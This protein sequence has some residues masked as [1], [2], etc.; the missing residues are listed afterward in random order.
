MADTIADH[1]V[2]SL[3][4]FR[5]LVEPT[6]ALSFPEPWIQRKIRDEQ[7]KFKVW[8][9]NI[10]AHKTGTGSLDYRLR[11]ASP[12]K[13]QVIELLEDLCDLLSQAIAIAS[14]EKIPWDQLDGE[15][16]V[17]DADTD[18]PSTELGQI[19]TEGVADV[20]DCLLRLSMT[21]RNPAPHDRFIMSQSA[22]TTYFEPFD[23]QHVQSK[24]PL[25]EPWLAERLGKATSRRRQYFRYR[26]SHHA[27]LSQGLDDTDPAPKECNETI[28]SSIPSHLK[29]KGKQPTILEDDRSDAGAS[30]TSYA[31]SIAEEGALRVPPLPEE[32]HE[33]PFQCPFCYVMVL[34]TDRAAW[35]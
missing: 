25:V 31:T 19:A 11:D 6:K 13:N 30:Q 12:I 3:A 1:V 23:I 32:S 34:V 17:E 8:A 15:E 24:F 4:A 26:E 18:S 33:G 21:I 16:S 20:V 7:T 22:D 29:D 10:G 5:G 14:G 2:R 27:K 35:K 9:G 28:A